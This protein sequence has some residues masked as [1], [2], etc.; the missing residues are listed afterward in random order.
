ML[1]QVREI[2]Q[3]KMDNWKEIFKVHDKEES[4]KLAERIRQL[5]KQGEETKE[6]L[7]TIVSILQG[8]E[9]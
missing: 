9:Y 3:E 6:R 5:E 7:T 1:K 2:E 8:L 4:Q